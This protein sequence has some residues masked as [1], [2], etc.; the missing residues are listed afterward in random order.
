VGKASR[1]IFSLDIGGGEGSV[2]DGGEGKKIG[3]EGES[4]RE[5]ALDDPDSD[6]G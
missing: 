2:S 3:E 1:S 5:E 6:D 4:A